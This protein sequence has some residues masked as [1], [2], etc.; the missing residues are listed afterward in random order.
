MAPHQRTLPHRSQIENGPR[1][2]LYIPRLQV[3]LTCFWLIPLGLQA[4]QVLRSQHYS[5][6]E[7]CLLY[8]VWRPRLIFLRMI[9]KHLQRR[10]KKK[11]WVRCR[12]PA[13]AELKINKIDRDVCYTPVRALEAPRA[14]KKRDKSQLQVQCSGSIN[15]TESLEIGRYYI[16]TWATTT[17][18]PGKK[19]LFSHW[20]EHNIN[21]NLGKRGFSSSPNEL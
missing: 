5:P 12:F 21:S 19:G 17:D 11:R 4:L 10:K 18:Q 16:R 15:S 1:C 3:F 2:C 6:W 7:E 20:F 9:K 14:Q 13:G 8:W